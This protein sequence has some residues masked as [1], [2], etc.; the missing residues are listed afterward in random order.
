M[1]IVFRI[2]CC[3][4]LIFFDVNMGIKKRRDLKKW[5]DFVEVDNW[6]YGDYLE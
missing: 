6:M 5:K 4:E 3:L 1:F 2:K